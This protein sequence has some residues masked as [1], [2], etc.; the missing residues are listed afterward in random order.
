MFM[1][2]QLSTNIGAYNKKTLAQLK[3]GAGGVQSSQLLLHK[4][5]GQCEMIYNLGEIH[6]FSL[7]QIQLQAQ[8]Q[9]ILIHIQ[10]QMLIPIQ[11]QK[12]IQLVTT[13]SVSDRSSS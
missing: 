6:I 11:K 2:Q 1:R 12:Q 8:T 10:I 4:P 13:W 9:I 3:G 5:P 7:V